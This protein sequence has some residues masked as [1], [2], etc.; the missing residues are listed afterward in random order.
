MTESDGTS[1]TCWNTVPMPSDRLARGEAIRTGLP[2]IRISPSSGCCMPARMPISVD[3]PAPFSPKQD[4]DLA[5][6][7]V[8]RDA[9]IGHHAG[10][11]LGDVAD[12]GNWNGQ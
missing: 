12:R 8:E 1:S 4:M 9:V 5:R 2:S 3:L 11:A 10:E 7:E 6:I